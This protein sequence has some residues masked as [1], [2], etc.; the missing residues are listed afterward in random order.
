[1]LLQKVGNLS[2]N[3]EEEGEGARSKTREGRKGIKTLRR[4]SF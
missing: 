3:K 1:L 2:Q 4:V